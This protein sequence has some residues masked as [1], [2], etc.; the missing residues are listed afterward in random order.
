MSPPELRNP[1]IV[2]KCNIAETQ[3]KDFKVAIKS[4]FKVLKNN[5]NKSI[6][7]IYEHTIKQWNEMKKT[8]QDMKLKMKSLSKIQ[9]DLKL[10]MKFI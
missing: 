1:L 10:E 3:G 8:I 4:M 5:V 2:E 9:T 7:E 6:N